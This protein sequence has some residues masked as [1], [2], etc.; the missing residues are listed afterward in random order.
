MTAHKTFAAG[1]PKHLSPPHLRADEQ[2]GQAEQQQQGAAQQLRRVFAAAGAQCGD[3]GPT[4]VRQRD[5]QQ[6]RRGKPI[7]QK[8]EYCIA[9]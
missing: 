8:A 3:K 1:R 4:C 2:D 5:L 6:R 9:L 7:I